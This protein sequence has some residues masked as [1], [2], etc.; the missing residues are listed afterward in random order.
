MS[1]DLFLDLGSEG[2]AGTLNLMIPGKNSFFK[3]VF[4]ILSP[5]KISRY[6]IPGDIEFFC[7]LPL[8]SIELIEFY[9]AL[10][11][12]HRLHLLNLSRSQ[13]WSRKED[14]WISLW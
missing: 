5:L 6:G 7:D 2:G 14:R 1:V 10:N 12:A 11:V 4:D 13:W 9:N 3:P 8:G